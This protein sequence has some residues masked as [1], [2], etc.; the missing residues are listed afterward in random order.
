MERSM[1]TLKTCE[2]YLYGVLWRTNLDEAR[3]VWDV[4]VNYHV[5]F[6]SQAVW[7]CFCKSSDMDCMSQ[8]YYNHTCLYTT[9][10]NHTC[11]IYSLWCSKMFWVLN[12]STVHVPWTSIHRHRSS[13]TPSPSE[14]SWRRGLQGVSWSKI[15]KHQIKCWNGIH[16]TFIERCF[17]IG[18]GIV[19]VFHIA[20]SLIV[21]IQWP[22]MNYPSGEQD[23]F[24]SISVTP[25]NATQ[26]NA[27]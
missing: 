23:Y 8:A 1:Q 25:P 17:W 26:G 6:I 13:Q 4:M 3:Q 15:H 19:I 10:L 24:L 16:D 9:I 2:I 11:V 5:S 14:K 12:H 20:G 22:V 21:W 7:R 27:I 18:N